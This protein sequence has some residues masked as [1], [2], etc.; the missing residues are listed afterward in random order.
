MKVMQCSYPAHKLSVVSKND[1]ML[2]AWTFT[3]SAVL[4]PG[5]SETQSCAVKALLAQTSDLDA[6]FGSRR[7]LTTDLMP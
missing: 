3:S 2:Y 6:F 4:C 5:S 1:G 7:Q